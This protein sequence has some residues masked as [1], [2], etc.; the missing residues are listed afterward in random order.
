MGKFIVEIDDGEFVEIDNV[1][2]NEG[3]DSLSNAMIRD[4]GPGWTH[5]AVGSGDTAPTV[6]DAAMEE[7]L[8][9]RPV[10]GVYSPATGVAR[11]L[12]VFSSKQG[13]GA[14]NELGIFDSE[15]IREWLSQCETI[16]GW[17]SDGTLSQET[18]VVH[19]AAASIK[20]TMSSGSSGDIAFS[21]TTLTNPTD[22]IG[23]ILT[24]DVFQ[25]WYRTTV[26]T[27]TLTVRLGTDS[28]NYYQWTWTPGVINEWAH[29]HEIFDDASETGSPGDLAYFR[30]TR[31]DPTTSVE[32]LDGLSVFR[33]NGVLMARGAIS[34]TKEYNTVRN[35]YYSVRV[36]IVT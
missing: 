1:I 26:D 25:F 35:V 5:M 2:T 21:T 22:E 31:N 15:E 28:S 23:S 12:G 32:Y 11:Y 4:S 3:R 13:N 19:Q 24:T 18:S 30:L 14:W 10:T 33:E 9:R 7:E 27:G 16:T 20:C 36:T 6:N 34:A 17:T 8:C 29:F